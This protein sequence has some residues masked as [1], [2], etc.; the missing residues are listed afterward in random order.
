MLKSGRYS[1][2]SS[3]SLVFGISLAEESCSGSYLFGWVF[4]PSQGF[5]SNLR[6]TCGV[7][8][9]HPW[10]SVGGTGFAGVSHLSPSLILFPAGSKTGPRE[11]EWPSGWALFLQGTAEKLVNW[12]K[13]CVYVRACACVQR[14]WLIER[15]RGCVVCV[16]VCWGLGQVSRG[17]SFQRKRKKQKCSSRALLHLCC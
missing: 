13:R 2:N 3:F 8:T 14:S 16:C 7:L 9:F 11:Q 15:R 4:K 12:E 17:P 10:C 6:W 5:L 1:D